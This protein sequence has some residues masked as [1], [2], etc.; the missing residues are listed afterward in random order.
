[1]KTIKYISSFCFVALLMVFGCDK[2]E[3]V[4]FVN[5]VAAP[6][7]ISA[8]VNVI[9]DNTGL[10]QI[11]PTGEGVA[12]YIV[13]FGDGSEVSE[14]LAPGEYA[15]HMYA[16]GTYEAKITGTGINGKSAT[17]TQTVNVSFRAP[18]NIEITTAIDGSNPFLLK[19]S[20]DADY[21]ASFIVFFDT[22]NPDEEG[23]PLEVGGTVSK[24]YPG[25]GDYTI[26]VIALSGGTESSE[27][28]QTVTISAPVVFPIDFEVF[29]A[30][31][32]IGFGG[33][34]AEVVPNPQIDAGNSS[35]TVGK[36]IKDAPEVWAGNVITMSSPIDF[37]TR[38]QMTMKVWSP[39][40]GGK[41]LMKI[42]NLDDGEI[43]H[44]KEVTLKGNSD[45]EEVTFNFSDIDLNQSYQKVVLFFDFGTVGSGGPE[46][47]F[48]V[49]DINQSTPSSGGGPLLY[50]DFE[51]NG[52]INTWAPDQSTIDIN[53]ANPVSDAINGSNTV[54]G[55]YDDGANGQ[56]ANVRFDAPSNFDLSG[57]NSKFTIKIYVPSSSL[58]ADG[59]APNQVSL[60]LQDGTFE[61]PWESQTE[62]IKPIV[63]DA[64]QEITFD[65]ATDPTLGED[66]P[67]G[68]TDFNRIVIQV[69]GENNFESVT[70]YIDDFE[71]G[72]DGGVID[73]PPFA[74]DDFEGNGTITTWAPDQAV[75]NASFANPF[76]DAVNPSATV[77]EYTDDGQQYANV[78]FDV[79]PNFD[80]EAKSKFTL[81]IYVPSSSLPA[82]GTAP[83][84]VS[85]K[86]QDGT[87]ERPWESQTEIIKPI[88]LDAWQEITF[89]F[90]NDTTVGEDNPTGRLDFSRVVIQ[91]NGENNFETVTAYIDDL[92][93]R[94]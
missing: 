85:L 89:D 82:D 34:S 16:E 25:V 66:N 48:Y 49:D 74:R 71:Y 8:G 3:N 20:A 2:D 11:T 17:G 68:R 29:D 56:Y 33:A 43:F 84:Q 15:E 5:S 90:A 92:V 22:S 70:A 35:Q 42:E 38:N 44:E 28:E 19:V 47:T 10:T 54:L 7:N 51:G 40:P 65:F 88:V 30:S 69:N 26:K 81:K 77:L 60:K 67:T 6:T 18:E 76:V 57:A 24:E 23:T 59:T 58:P 13:D 55:Y 75:L 83:N 87:F 39:K 78:R 32:F 94:N 86:L 31:A 1:M 52:N 53:L 9:P 21:A 37:S 12:S 79:T 27:L 4:D 36:I 63:L 45:W 46:W 62:I 41:L 64:W 61:R 73:T 50:D 14:A 91:V 72:E 93:Y 80:M